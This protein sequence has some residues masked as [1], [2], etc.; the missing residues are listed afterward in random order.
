MRCGVCR[1]TEEV[2]GGE[3]GPPLWP[4]EAKGSLSG[5]WTHP[6]AAKVTLSI[7]GFV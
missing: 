4:K 3:A 1:P 2:G 7:N 5:R 6:G